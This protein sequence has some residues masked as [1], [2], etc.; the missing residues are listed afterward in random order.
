[1]NFL[2][3]KSLTNRHFVQP[4]RQSFRHTN[5]PLMICDDWWLHICYWPSEDLPLLTVR[6]LT[7]GRYAISKKSMPRTVIICNVCEFYATLFIFLYNIVLWTSLYREFFSKGNQ[8]ILAVFR[9]WRLSC[10]LVPI[11]MS[12]VHL[13]GFVNSNLNNKFCILSS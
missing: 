3:S 4:S 6:N 2:H 11:K 10:N 5:F 1:M 7:L 12:R 9:A 13:F 8:I